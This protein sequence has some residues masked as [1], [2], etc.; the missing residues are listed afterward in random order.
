MGGWGDG[1]WLIDLKTAVSMPKPRYDEERDETR[2]AAVG[3]ER[4]P[5]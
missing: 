5:P 4:C 3:E 2:H 1:V